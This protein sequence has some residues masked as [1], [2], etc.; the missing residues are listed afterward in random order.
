MGERARIGLRL[1]DGTIAARYCQWAHPM[2]GTGDYLL[3][4]YKSEDSVQKLLERANFDRIGC[5]PEQCA[6]CDDE[7]SPVMIFPNK[8]AMIHMSPWDMLEWWYLY[9]AG[10]WH[11]C[12]NH[13]WVDLQNLMEHYY[14]DQNELAREKAKHEEELKKAVLAQNATDKAL[15]GGENPIST[16]RVMFSSLAGKEDNPPGEDPC[17][18]H[19]RKPDPVYETPSKGDRP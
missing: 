7:D 10:H 8:E 13:C 9:E 18:P 11:I 6:I 12:L 1:K 16:M 19:T 3:M 2:H 14:T 17:Y 15:Y 4:Y 5:T